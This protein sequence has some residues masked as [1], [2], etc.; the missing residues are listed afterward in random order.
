MA[1]KER[2]YAKLLQ[3]LPWRRSASVTAC[4]DLREQDL[5]LVVGQGKLIPTIGEPKVYKKAQLQE[6]HAIA[7]YAWLKHPGW[8]L[9]YGFAYSEELTEAL[10][11]WHAH[12]FCLDEKGR[13]IEPT[14]NERTLYW[15]VVLDH[16][17][18][19][20]LAWEEL[21]NIRNL[22][23]KVTNQMWDKLVD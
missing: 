17:G 1:R 14:P 13:I 10:S 21:E 22:G 4:E 11:S 2:L 8:K 19:Q 16:A 12:S 20:R 6:C 23:L 7:A 5:R 15:G 9:C 18:A 3:E